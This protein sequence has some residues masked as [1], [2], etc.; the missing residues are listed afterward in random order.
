MH[1]GY[2]ARKLGLGVA[3]PR[4]IDISP[5]D[6]IDEQLSIPGGDLA[7]RSLER[8]SSREVT[9]WPEEL[10]FSLRERWLREGQFNILRNK[11]D[12]KKITGDEYNEKLKYYDN[13]F[14][15]FEDLD[16]FRFAHSNVYSK[17]HVKNRLRMFWINHFTKGSNSN[18]GYGGDFEFSIIDHLNGSFRD[19]LYFS[20]THVGLLHYLDNH[21]SISPQ[22]REAKACKI[23]GNE[24]CI[25][26]LNDNFARELL[27]L[28]TV[29]PNRNYTEKDIAETSKVLAGWGARDETDKRAALEEPWYPERAHPG[30]KT[31]L[32]Q[33]IRSGKAG[34]RQ[35]TDLLAVDNETIAHLS[36]KMVR[37]FCGE[38]VN[39]GDVSSVI[40]VWQETDGDL[41]AIH[42]EVLLRAAY[43]PDRKFLWPL[44]WAFQVIRISG[45]HVLA[46][47]ED[48]IQFSES[49]TGLRPEQ[50]K[51][52][53][54]TL[55][56]ELGI[57]FWNQR[58]PD[59]YSDLKADWVSNEHIDRRVRLSSLVFSARKNS[60]KEKK[61]TNEEIMDA[62]RFSVR[63]RNI[64]SRF[65][66]D[67]KNQFSFLMCS[68][69]MMEV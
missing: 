5:E 31:V 28:H 18:N 40:K 33:K 64:A 60:A 8:R 53:P 52:L 69:E 25:L 54:R 2:L 45:G 7:L 4:D 1:E 66:S 48:S 23:D 67:A 21:L 68:S 57:D 62:Q 32:G 49:K 56:E 20:A 55:Y 13:K 38:P 37:H 24:L 50:S 6:Y 42:R 22:S 43:K 9:P 46:G 29:S 14:R 44:I 10:S 47:Y 11:L 16:R 27:E 61:L 17:N 34:L 12:A 41:N 51:L 19:L 26:G 59:G 15:F 39:K 63:T 35:L 30:N 58:T 3:N 36:E 65:S